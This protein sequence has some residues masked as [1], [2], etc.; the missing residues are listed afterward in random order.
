MANQFKHPNLKAFKQ[1]GFIPQSESGGTQVVGRCPFCGTNKK[2]Y[3]NPESKAWDCKVCGKEGGYQKFL[4]QMVDHC[5]D[6]FTGKI[7]KKLMESRGLRKKT[8]THFGVGYNPLTKAYT[9]PV[10]DEKEQTL[11]NVRV[12]KKGEL[13]NTSG[14]NASLFGLPE[15][16]R[17]HRSIWLCEGEWDSMAMWEVLERTGKHDDSIILG[18]PG[19]ATFKSDWQYLFSDKIVHVAY[20]NDFDKVVK[21]VFR[22]GA[23]KMGCRK[24][25]NNIISTVKQIDFINWPS[26]YD[27]GFDI[28]DFYV[29]KREGNALKTVRGLN[30]LL[31]KTPPPIIYPEGYEPTEEDAEE[32]GLPVLKLDGKGVKPKD[33]YAEWREWLKIENTDCIDVLYGTVIA[34]RFSN[35]PVWLFFVGPSGSMKSDL[36]M[37]LDDWDETYAI[38]SLTPNTLISGQ[39][40]QNRDP[41]LVPQLDGKILTIKDFTTI[42]QMQVMARDAIISQLR[43]AFD[44]KCAKPF[45]TGARRNYESKFGLISGVTQVIEQFLEGGTAMGERFLTYLLK[46]DYTYDEL[47]EIMTRVIDNTLESKK[48]EMRQA[49][50]AL[51]REVLNYD[52]GNQVAIEGIYREKMMAL[53]WYV[54][55]MRGSVTRDKFKKAEITHR[56]Y[57]ELP[58]RIISQMISLSQGIT[59][60]RRKTKLKQAEYN[61]MKHIAIGSV[62]YHE[63]KIIKSIWEEDPKDKYTTDDFCDLL[64]LPWDVAHRYAE[65]LAQLGMLRKKTTARHRIDAKYYLSKDAI[66]SITTSEIFKDIDNL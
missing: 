2:F 7:A 49:L 1:H 42:L 10:W 53:A 12:Y 22:P 14:C 30:A 21:E 20:D 19:A 11:L 6:N 51:S 17:P 62:P 25:K 64:R 46:S 39:A 59:L 56:P 33:V 8:L 36:V 26:N 61:T 16:R 23:G 50:K 40:T 15:I 4:R 37:A 55:R 9:I 43:D 66:R 24:V 3:I 44:G 5:I 29:K 58:T 48:S 34:N 18:T 27:D 38:S 54:S 28:R 47:C 63:E 45:G 60:F 13:R 52:F 65:N 57:I 32:A 35:D 41:S 31:R